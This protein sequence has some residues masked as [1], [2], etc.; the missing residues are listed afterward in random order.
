VEWV[1]ARPVVAEQLR[2]LAE[3]D[4]RR[5]TGL[6]Q[7]DA[8]MGPVEWTPVISWLRKN[9]T[10]RREIVGLVRDRLAAAVPQSVN[11]EVPSLPPED[12]A[13]A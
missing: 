13:G 6:L 4:D 3:A 12:D 9:P 10:K 7:T 5:I 8:A 11:G 1:F 2:P